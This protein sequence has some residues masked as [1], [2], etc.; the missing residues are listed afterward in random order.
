[1][2]EGPS[3]ADCEKVSLTPSPERTKCMRWGDCLCLVLFLD[4]CLFR[5]H[6][7]IYLWAP[8]AA[9][10]HPRRRRRHVHGLVGQEKEER[11]LRTGYSSRS[12]SGT[13]SWRGARKTIHAHL[14][15][16]KHGASETVRAPLVTRST[17]RYDFPLPVSRSDNDTGS[18]QDHLQDLGEFNRRWSRIC[19]SDQK[20]FG[21]YSTH[22][23]SC[24]LLVSRHKSAVFAL[25]LSKMNK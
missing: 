5:S 13:Q 3:A 9:C 16:G 11:N 20:P 18:F 15:G 2:L 17:R 1:M 24:V 8:L 21:A 14:S 25:C 10:M 7:T 6:A 4:F 22:S 19:I 23:A 12:R